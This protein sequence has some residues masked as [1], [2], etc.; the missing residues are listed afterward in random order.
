MSGSYYRCIY[1]FIQRRQYHRLL[2]KLLFPLLPIETS[3]PASAG[4]SHNLVAFRFA[5]DAPSQRHLEAWCGSVLSTAGLASL[6]LRPPASVPAALGSATFLLP[7]WSAGGSQGQI[8]GLAR[9]PLSPWCFGQSVSV[10][11]EHPALFTGW[12]F[13][14]EPPWV[15]ELSYP[16]AEVKSCPE[17]TSWGWASFGYRCL[18]S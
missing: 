3:C 15:Y 1:R 4:S 5:V 9:K 12:L 10:L 8:S 18:A 14:V 17:H 2:W 6:E 7:T 11:E 16:P 13:P